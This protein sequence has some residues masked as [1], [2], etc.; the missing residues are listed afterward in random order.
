MFVQS[1]ML[2]RTA[3]VRKIAGVNMCAMLWREEVS[4]KE[5]DV[6]SSHV[7]IIAER[8]LRLS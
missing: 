6:V 5:D 2:W 8:L 1:A 4:D 7:Q 3:E